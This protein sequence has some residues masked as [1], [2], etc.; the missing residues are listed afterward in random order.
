MRFFGY[1]LDN[2]STMPTEPPSPELMQE[3]GKFVQEAFDAGV[4]IA[5]GGMA[6]TEQG[7]K[8]V[9]SGGK[10]TVT[11]GPFAEAKEI[12]GG[13]ALMEAPT[14]EEAIEWAKR[15]RLIAG[16]GES[17]LRPVMF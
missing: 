11:D 9:N 16:E 13:W 14:M 10:L 1:T 17:R 2:E 15:F 6:P 5:T 3:M 4:L 12:V 8:I 7:V